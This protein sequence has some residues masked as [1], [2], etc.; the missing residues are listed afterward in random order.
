MLIGSTE[1]I[2]AVL[3]V[4]AAND[5]N[6]LK[7]HLLN[8][9]LAYIKPL[10]GTNMYEE[11]CEFYEGHPYENPNDAQI[12]TA[13]LLGKVQHSIVHLGYYL[14][15]EFLNVTVSDMGFTRTESQ[16]SKSLYR[17]QEDNLRDYFKN[18]GFNMLDEILLFMEENIAHFDEFALSNTYTVFRS[19]FIQTA[20]AFSNIYFINNSRLTFLRLQPHIR[21]I[22]DTEIKPLLGTDVYDL[23]KTGMITEVIPAKVVAVLPYIRTPLAF[24]SAALLMEESGADLTEKG[25]YFQ[26][27]MPSTQDSRQITPAAAERIALLV[28]RA[29]NMGK[30]YLEMLKTYM[31]DNV[32][33]W[34]DYSTES[35]SIFNRDNS[36]KKT[37]WA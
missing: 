17:Y 16:T 19:A 26:S 33:D 29:R 31:A 25:L 15:F 14:G 23:I 4:G 6:R 8:A 20:V 10:L 35:G 22:E 12:A 28:A 32:E 2:K 1:E 7:P 11:L 21:F 36:G 34:E 5:F 37:F 3:S 24:L 30:A 9:E 18:G 27:T 13:T